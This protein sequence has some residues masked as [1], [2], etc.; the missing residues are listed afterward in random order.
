MND[1][2]PFA[3]LAGVCLNPVD[4]GGVVLTPVVQAVVDVHL[5]AVA[6]E[7]VRTLTPCKIKFFK[8]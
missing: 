2:V 6:A 1:S 8:V 3:A 7:A 4:T 5:A